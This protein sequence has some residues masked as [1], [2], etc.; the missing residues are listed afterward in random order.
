PADACTV[1]AGF[2][3]NFSAATRDS[4]WVPRGAGGDVYLQNNGV[5]SVSSPAGDPN[6]LLYEKAGY[7]ATIQ[8][9]LMRVK[10]KTF[11]TH[12]DNRAGVGLSVASANS[13]GWD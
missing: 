11:Q 2:Q 5:L 3:D 7:N 12:V 13:Q 10:V 1:V 4:L 9:A 6:H 8:E